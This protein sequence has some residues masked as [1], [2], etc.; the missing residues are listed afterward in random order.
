[1]TRFGKLLNPHSIGEQH[2]LKGGFC[3][4]LSQTARK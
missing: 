2:Y 1:M 3:V 4:T